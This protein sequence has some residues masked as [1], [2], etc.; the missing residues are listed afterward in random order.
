MAQ[1]P[2]GIS[3]SDE[4]PQKRV[5]DL[6][7]GKVIDLTA[8]AVAK[9]KDFIQKNVKAQGKYF[10]VYVEGGGCSGMQYGFT[11]DERKEDDHLVPCGDIEVLVDKNSESYL[12]SSVVDYV[13]GLGGTGFVV[14]NPQAKAS[15]GCGTSFTV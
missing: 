8:E 2:M 3:F 6:N 12:K 1:S 4:A 10:R 9:V 14:E 5:Y 13:E 11:F 7:H 15:C